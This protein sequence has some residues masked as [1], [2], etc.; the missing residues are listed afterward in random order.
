MWVYLTF[1]YKDDDGREQKAHFSKRFLPDVKV[2]NREEL[3]EDW[4]SIIS[5]YAAKCGNGTAVQTLPDG[6]PVTHPDM[7]RMMSK[8]QK[9]IAKL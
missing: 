7:D 4:K 8:I 1:D 3:K 6:T 5:D 2:T 9:V